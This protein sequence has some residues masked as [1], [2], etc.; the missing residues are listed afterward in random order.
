MNAITIASATI[1]RPSVQQRRGSV[2]REPRWF[3]CR[4]IG[5]SNSTAEILIE[6]APTVPER[7]DNA[8][9]ALFQLTRPLDT[10]E[11]IALE[12]TLDQPERTRGHAARRQLQRIRVQSPEGRA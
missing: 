10:D 11:F 5:I 8:G 6:E 3:P 4:E 1:D 7:V 12:A 9:L 2:L